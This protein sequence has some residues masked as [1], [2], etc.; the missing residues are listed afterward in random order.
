MNPAKS[1]DGAQLIASAALTFM[2]GAYRFAIL[3]MAPIGFAILWMAPI[4]F[5]NMSGQDVWT[6]S[7]AIRFF[8]GPNSN[9]PFPMAK[10]LKPN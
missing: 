9:G 1:T 4:G 7:I 6:A 3:W 10:L 2:N 5:A 8:W